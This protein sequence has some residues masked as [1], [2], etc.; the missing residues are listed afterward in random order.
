MRSEAFDF[1]QVNY[2]ADDRAAEDRILPL[3]ADRGMAVLVNLPF[4]GGG[5]LRRFRERPLPSWA[6]DIGCTSWAQVFLKFV[7][8]N[9]AVTC[10]IPGTANPQHMAENA[11]AGT[12]TPLDDAMR[13]LL[14]SELNR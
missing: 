9:P 3:A 13:R 12:G 14:L 6:A 5:L 11:R 2:S 1:I 10:A 4:G 7:L 8:A